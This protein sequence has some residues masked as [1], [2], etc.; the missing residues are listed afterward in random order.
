MGSLN[1]SEEFPQRED[2]AYLNHAGVA[3]WPRRTA[4]AVNRFAD[5]N[6][7]QGAADYPRWLETEARLKERLRRL[8]NAPCVDDIALLKNTSEALSVV[9]YGLIWEPGDN[10]V[11]SDQEF[12]SNRVVWQS[13]A[14]AGVDVRLADLTRAE[15][16]E[17]ALIAQVD[18]R[19]RL[20]AISSVQYGT[21][22][23]MDLR[24]LGQFCAERG[25]WFCVD[26]IQSVGALRT[27]VQAMQADFLMADGHKWMLGPEGVALFYTR[28]EARDS[29][30]LT[31]YG[32]HMVEHLGDYQRQDWQPAGSSRRFECGSPNMLGIAAL[33]ASL[34]LFQDVGMAEVERRV[35]ENAA[36]VIERVLAHPA[37]ELVTP[38]SAGRY[39][40]I[41][42]FR[43]LGRNPD[44]V[45]RYLSERGVICAQRAGGIRLSPHF[46]TPKKTLDR[47]LAYAA[48]AR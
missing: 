20:L 43:P 4:Q 7:T 9:A 34:S 29:L 11:I 33:E 45:F 21:G 25:I 17:D 18:G 37:L 47:A 23:R 12:P 26:A 13:L 30:R 14:H 1:L 36:Y 31:Q 48:D 44:E 42:T 40:G 39:G 38:P 35:L 41:V 27:D 5:E 15:T 8:I 22:L 28:P 46:Y 2:I 24:R 3:P 19:T 16:P 10:I 6:I 32:W